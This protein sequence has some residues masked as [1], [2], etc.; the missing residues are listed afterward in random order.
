MKMEQLEKPMV[1][2]LQRNM[3]VEQYP[4]YMEHIKVIKEELEAQNYSGETYVIEGGNHA[5]F[6]N[7]G[8]QAGD[9]VGEIS[10]E[11][12]QRETVGVISL[13]ITE[14]KFSSVK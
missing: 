6:G 12:Q 4:Q 5:Y 13:W 7:Y 3:F 2:N 14:R 9:S 10:R 11:E 1:I 8:E